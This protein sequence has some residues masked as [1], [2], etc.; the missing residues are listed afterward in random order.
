LI[1]VVGSL[2]TVALTVASA[3][4]RSVDG[5]VSALDVQLMETLFAAVIVTV[6][7][8]VATGVAT[9][10]ATMVT[11]PPVLMGIIEGAWYVVAT[12]LV[13]AV[14]LNEPQVLPVAGVHIADQ[15]TPLFMVSFWSVATT[16]GA[17]VPAA[18]E[19]GGGEEMVTERVGFVM[20]VMAVAIAGLST[21]VA[22][23]VTGKPPAGTVAG[24]V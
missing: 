7:I 11:T 16:P 22:V 14:G 13:V 12:P 4:R 20:L 5:G 3:D 8:A 1:P 24:A 9:V 15:V 2:V 23:I 18:I 10:V 6:A 19:E 21:D 17:V